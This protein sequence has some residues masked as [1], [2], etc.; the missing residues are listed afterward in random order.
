MSVSNWRAILVPLVVLALAAAL[1]HPG[2]CRVWKESVD[3]ASLSVSFVLLPT[4]FQFFGGPLFIFA[5]S[6]TL[7][8]SWTR[9][10]RSSVFF[11]GGVL[12][13]AWISLSWINFGWSNPGDATTSGKFCIRGS[14][15]REYVLEG[16]DSQK[17]STGRTKKSSILISIHDGR[18]Y[19]PMF[20]RTGRSFFEK[21]LG[22]VSKSLKYI[23]WT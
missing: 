8:I 5:S 21:R 13:S 10:C 12:V 1:A 15:T 7:V 14:W 16:G 17:T 11:A 18:S 3:S 20:W 2:A 4:L 19:S 22:T 9:D 23:P 6:T